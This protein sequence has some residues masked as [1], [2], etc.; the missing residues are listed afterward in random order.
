L[1][2][3][4]LWGLV[5]GS[6]LVVGGA[7]ALTL[8]ISR[9]ALGLIMAF[10]AGMLI[11]AVAY[12]LVDDAVRT[13]AGSGG[14]AFGLFAG[15]LTFFVGDAVIDRL[16]GADRKDSGGGQAGGSAPAIVL[17]IVLDGIPE[18]A[19]IGLSLLG[20]GGVSTAVIA[21]VFISNVPEAIAATTGLA[22]S[23]WRPRQVMLLWAGVGLVCA[24]AAP[25][26]YG[27]ST[28][29][30]GAA[31][32]SCRPSPAARSSPCWPTR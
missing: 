21:A 27:F 29:P 15:A 20:G 5:A 8:P 28:T 14:V 22:A 25:A 10:G 26:G 23:G 13:S 19:V 2:E 11:S 9:L 1:A 12:D 16:G 17:G 7:L 6:S 31:W 3:A 30:P 4:L 18:T 32:R 24:L